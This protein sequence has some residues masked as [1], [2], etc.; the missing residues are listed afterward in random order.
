MKALEQFDGDVV[1]NSNNGE[2][3]IDGLQKRK[4]FSSG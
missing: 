2:V 4:G 1:A 3:F